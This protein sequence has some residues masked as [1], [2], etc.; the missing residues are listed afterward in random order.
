MQDAP[1]PYGTATHVAT[2]V[3]MPFSVLGVGERWMQKLQ[4]RAKALSSA[5]KRAKIP[6]AVVGGMA[7]AAHVARVDEAAER[8]TK[9]IDILLNRA[10]FERA[11]DVLKTAGFV[12]QQGAGIDAFVP[13]GAGFREAVHI[14]WTGEKLRA[15]T[16]LPAPAL[17][18]TFPSP[19]GFECVNLRDLVVIKLTAYRL[20]DQVHIQDL[21]DLGLITAEI[22]TSLQPELRM[23]LQQVKEQTEREK[24]D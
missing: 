6:H 5:L 7:V 23:R 20:K 17:G 3:A 8:G 9:D 14:V 10:D 18:E 15:D 24:P 16:L 2:T 21:L 12:F 19:R 22:E 4:K 1:A 13:K 11:R